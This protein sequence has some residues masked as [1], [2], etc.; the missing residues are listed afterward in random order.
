MGHRGVNQKEKIQEFF[1]TFLSTQ[2][3]HGG[4]R[5]S[6]GWNRTQVMLR[7]VKW[8]SWQ[9]V[10]QQ[11]VVIFLDLVGRNAGNL[12]FIFDIQYLPTF[13]RPVVS[14]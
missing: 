4:G 11:T 1:E 13:N 5:K 10:Q 8:I 14:G 2:G 6:W 7:K 9:L 3:C 12:N